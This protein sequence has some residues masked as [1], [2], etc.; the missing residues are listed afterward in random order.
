MQ[1]FLILLYFHQSFVIFLYSLGCYSEYLRSYYT[2]E[3]RVLLITSQ[4]Y[5]LA[6]LL[7]FLLLYLR[8]KFVSGSKGT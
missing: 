5:I 7:C 8:Y 1:L 3:G 6:I 4:S 2:F